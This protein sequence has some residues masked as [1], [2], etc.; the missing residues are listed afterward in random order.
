MSFIMR[1]MFMEL[2]VWIP[3]IRLVRIITT[4][5]LFAVIFVCSAVSQ[6]L[7]PDMP[8]DFGFT[9][10]YGYYGKNILNTC[11]QTFTKD[12][13]L[14]CP[15]TVNLAF[16]K[17]ELKKVYDK[18]MELGIM[19]FPGSIYPEESVLSKWKDADRKIDLRKSHPIT[20][21]QLRVRMNGVERE[22]S[23]IIGIC[24]GPNGRIPY[25]PF[26]LLIQLIQEILFNKME[27]RDLPSV[28]VVYG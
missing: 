8:K 2:R 28:D 3:I 23:F 22:L 1:S 16:T 20:V 19:C 5:I 26:H 14:Q 27:Y 15:V 25:T 7:P 4:S 21:E 9:L 17:T 18:I 13:I 11:D 6:K 24:R 10:R 12:M